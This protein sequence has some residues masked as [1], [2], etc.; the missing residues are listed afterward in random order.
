MN[1]SLFGLFSAAETIMEA[2]Q[3]IA[4]LL[5]LI[6]M[7]TLVCPAAVNRPMIPRSH[8]LIRTSSDATR[9]RK[10]PQGGLPRDSS[11]TTIVKTNIIGN[12]IPQQ[13]T[14]H[15][16]AGLGSLSENVVVPNVE[17]VVLP[18]TTRLPRP[19]TPST[20]AKAPTSQPQANDRDAERQ[21]EI[22]EN[23]RSLLEPGRKNPPKPTQSAK[24]PDHVVHPNLYPLDHESC[25]YETKEVT[26]RRAGCKKRVE[27]GVCFGT[28]RS[29]PQLVKKVP[30]VQYR[31][32][33]CR[34]N[35]IPVEVNMND[36]DCQEQRRAKG[37]P[38]RGERYK[39]VFLLSAVSCSCALC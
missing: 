31:L 12:P 17:Q 19:S 3:L 6:T 36:D 30:Y 34:A 15:Q 16:P 4:P 2:F 28:C 26:V 11:R 39:D 25:R 29:E 24:A 13:Q 32:R 23:Y 18:R 37:R 9:H 10:I 22:S 1:L 27:I 35:Q 38:E 5:L 14:L 7:A 21:Q 8:Q 33:C 20:R